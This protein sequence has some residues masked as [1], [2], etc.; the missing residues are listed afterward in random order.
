MR[1]QDIQ[2]TPLQAPLLQPFR[3]ATGEHQTLDNFLVTLKLESGVVGYGE[4][5]IA[6]HITGETLTE[7]KEHLGVASRV[8]I[9]YSVAE[10]LKISNWLHDSFPKNKA[11]VAAVET[12]V[13]DALTQDIKIFGSCGM[14]G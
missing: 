5:A 1:I 3:I 14:F 7:T 4:A 6:T 10:Y 2:I 13:L 11:V 12:A 9:G 8:L